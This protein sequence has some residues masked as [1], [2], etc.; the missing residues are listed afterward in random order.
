MTFFKYEESEY[1]EGIELEEYNGVYS[2]VS[3]RENDGKVYKQWGYPQG[4]GKG[5]GPIEKCLPWKV[6]L[7]SR[8]EAVK[9]LNQLVFELGGSRDGQPDDTDVPF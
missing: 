5:A 8:E 9:V 1:G 7:G 6:K 2:L 4:R 3:A